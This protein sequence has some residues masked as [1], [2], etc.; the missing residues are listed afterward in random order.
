MLSEQNTRVPPHP[1]GTAH[2]LTIIVVVATVIVVACVPT[3]PRGR[4]RLLAEVPRRGVQTG[5]TVGRAEAAMGAAGGE[6]GFAVHPNMNLLSLQQAGK[7]APA[8]GLASTIH[9]QCHS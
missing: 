4:T 5:P 2:P 9:V 1:L 8:E 6:T 7:R 3:R